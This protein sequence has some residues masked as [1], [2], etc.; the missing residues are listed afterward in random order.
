ML[1]ELI[2]IEKSD[3]GTFGVLKLNGGAF[4]V[5]LE[6]EDKDNKVNI[7]CI[8]EGEYTCKRVFSPKY[9]STFEVTEVDGRSH[10]L[11]HA[12][13]V[14][15]NTKGCILLAQYF[16]KL[17]GARAVLNSGNTFRRFREELIRVK[18]FKLK[19]ISV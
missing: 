1:V 5:T 19:I 3:H 9:G 10:I 6:P 7:S 12:G 18:E 4:C 11:F 15:T 8:P 2:R 14:E 13:N 17:K 16:G